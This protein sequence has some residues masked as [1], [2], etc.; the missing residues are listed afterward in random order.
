MLITISGT[1]GSGKTTVAKLLS[2][3]LGVPHVYAGDIYRQEAQRRQMS[4]AELNA[5]AE[6][7]HSIDRALDE[8]MAAY[9]RAGGVVLEGR[10]AAFVARQENV[11]ALKVWLT[12][13]DEIRADRVAQ[14]EQQD[15]Q[16]VLA[17]NTARHS[18]DANRYKAIY[19][20]DLDDTSIYDVIIVTDERRP[21]D[22]AAELSA[23]AREY[24][25]SEELRTPT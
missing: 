8:R 17:Q 22:V 9:A 16:A 2:A 15:S 24:F 10:L 7:D 19:G 5:L 14:R 21:E 3:Q 13:S 25:S 11:G 20:W 4:L 1:P 12:A 6:A 23:A 18:S